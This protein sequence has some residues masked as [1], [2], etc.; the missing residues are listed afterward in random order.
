MN[1]KTVKL[2]VGGTK[3]ITFLSTVKW[4]L[5]GTMVAS[6]VPIEI[7]DGYIFIDRDGKMFRHV[8]NYLRDERVTCKDR[9]IS[10]FLQELDYFAISHSIQDPEIKLLEEAYDILSD[11]KYGPDRELPFLIETFDE[12]LPQKICMN[13]LIPIFKE[14][15]ERDK[16]ILFLREEKFITIISKS[17]YGGEAWFVAN[18]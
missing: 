15:I 11:F 9:D 5:I 13:V 3:Y 8:L 18:R 12:I 6:K 14:K 1:K 10:I 17:M 4:T 16:F 7:I 2:N